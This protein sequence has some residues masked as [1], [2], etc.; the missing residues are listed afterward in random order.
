MLRWHEIF[1]RQLRRRGWLVVRR[2]YDLPIPHE[3][4]LSAGF[5]AYDSKLVGLE[6]DS[7]AALDFLNRVVVPRLAEFRREFHDGADSAF[8]LTNGRFMA[9]DAH[10]YYALIRSARPKRVIE[11]GAGQSTLVAA[12]AVTR[13]AEE[14]DRCFLTAIDP[15]PPAYLSPDIPGVSDVVARKVQDLPL[16]EFSALGRDDVL[17][18]DSSHAFRAGGDVHFELC[19]LLPRLEPGVFV[20]F[21][22]ISLP[23]PYPRVY[24]EQGLYWN[25]QYALQAFLAFNSQFEVVWPGNYMMVNHPEPL[26]AAIPEIAAMRAAFPASEPTSFWL[27][28]RG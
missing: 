4:E 7:A 13:N 2:T 28:V 15:M 26:L 22:D 25:E 18:I 27:R 10:V 23:K 24:F 14:G 6:I 9:V 11:V 16:A 8:H 3:E 20:H 19:E 5:G 21:H 12:A 17:F 1:Q